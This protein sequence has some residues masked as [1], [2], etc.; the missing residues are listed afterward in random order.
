MSN[1]GVVPVS[2]S[3]VRDDVGSSERNDVG[4]EAVQRNQFHME[5]YKCLR[6]EILLLK[7][8]QFS[9]QK[10]ITVSLGIIYGLELGMGGEK[11]Y[12]VLPKIN[13]L[14]LALAGFGI[15][16]IGA[17]FYSISDY[18]MNHISRYVQQIE[19]R[20]AK[21][22]EPKGWEHYQGFDTDKRPVW[23]II[24]NPFWWLMLTVA[25]LMVLYET[26]GFFGR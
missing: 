10:W 23:G 22:G 6:A 20:F 25:T 16:G 9:I 24:R 11:A 7:Q 18:T 21:T 2:P 19:S 13:S 14:L 1:G 17:G 26:C 15:A 5:E 8:H 12:Y 4:E 3:S